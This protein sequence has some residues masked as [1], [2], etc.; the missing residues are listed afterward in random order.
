MRGAVEDDE[1]EELEDGRAAGGMCCSR[2]FAC[3]KF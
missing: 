1:A 2:I 3:E